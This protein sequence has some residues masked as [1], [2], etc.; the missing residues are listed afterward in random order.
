M[1]QPQRALV[2][3]LGG[4][5]GQYVAEALHREGYEVLG[6][7]LH[8][9]AGVGTQ[10]AW[11]HFELDL[12]DSDAVNRVVRETQPDVVI[13]LAGVSFVGASDAAAF[14]R[15]HVIG[16]RHLLA[17][18]AE[19]PRVPRCVLLASSANV[20]GNAGSVPLRE[21]AAP[22][23][24]NDYAVSKLAMEQMAQLWT[25][26]LPIVIVRPFNYTGVGQ[27]SWFLLPK[28]VDHFR[29]RETAIE[30]GNL[31]VARDF[32]DVRSVAAAY[33]RLV[34]CCPAGK[35]FNICSGKAHRLEQILGMMEEIAGYR[36]DVRVHPDFVRSSDVK[37]L[38]GNRA[39]LDAAIGPTE[40]IPLRET[41]AWML[42]TDT[43]R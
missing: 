28:I 29:R 31:D 35:T 3:G 2:T 23:P 13:H 41:L 32:S 12:L 37:L 10:P 36:I 22:R 14:Y 9:P 16:T 40:W 25:D 4:F 26:R 19:L 20:Y 30:L 27:P 38:V 39:R 5:T 21:D 15:V 6:T 18:L 7:G 34:Q 11:R 24:A 33:L 1:S 8:A 42:Q 17:A 43:P